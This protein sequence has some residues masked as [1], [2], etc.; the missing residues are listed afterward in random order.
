MGDPVP[1]AFRSAKH[2][3]FFHHGNILHTIRLAVEHAILWKQDRDI[4]EA[5]KEKYSNYFEE[6]MHE[7]LQ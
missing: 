5:V 7:L 6:G 1:P 2:G 3:I 4:A